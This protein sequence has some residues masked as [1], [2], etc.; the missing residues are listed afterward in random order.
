M[1]GDVEDDDI[2]V[3]SEED[4]VTPE[5]VT[6]FSFFEYLFWNDWMCS[7]VRERERGESK[8]IIVKRT[9]DA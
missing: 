7:R 2:V 6:T 1:E 8:I 5:F 3:G 9:S 4:L